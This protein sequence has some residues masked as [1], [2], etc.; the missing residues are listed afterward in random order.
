MQPSCTLNRS[1]LC[2]KSELLC[3]VN[4]KKVILSNQDPDNSLLEV[5][6]DVLV[7][8]KALN[9]DT[10]I[11]DFMIHGKYSWISV[12]LL[13]NCNLCSPN[14]SAG[15]L[16]ATSSSHLLPCQAWQQQFSS[17]EDQG[18]SSILWPQGKVWRWV[19]HF[20]LEMLVWISFRFIKAVWKD[21]RKKRRGFI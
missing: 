1:F 5:L 15:I 16:L 14:R 7:L 17:M 9:L 8:F 12:L 6:P 19:W 10:R 3:P 18:I 13:G 11:E 20:V 4:F 2:S 21:V